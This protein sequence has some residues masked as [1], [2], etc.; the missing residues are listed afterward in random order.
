MICSTV[1]VYLLQYR[2]PNP[3]KMLRTLSFL[4]LFVLVMKVECSSSTDALQDVQNTTQAPKVL[5]PAVKSAAPN[6]TIKKSKQDEVDILPPHYY[7]D[8]APLAKDRKPVK[9]TVSL[10]ILNIKLSQGSS[11]VLGETCCLFETCI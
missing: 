5:A 8:V 6:M 11:Q 7:R 10:V 4:L 9:V 2:G 3:S 1:I